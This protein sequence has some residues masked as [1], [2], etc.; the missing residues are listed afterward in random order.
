MRVTECD[1]DLGRRET[2][3]RELNDVFDD[4]LRRRF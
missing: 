2:L 1:T 4:V 3:A